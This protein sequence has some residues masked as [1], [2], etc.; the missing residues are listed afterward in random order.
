MDTSSRANLRGGSRGRSLDASRDC[1]PSR[2]GLY[3]SGCDRDGDRDRD[4]DRDRARNRGDSCGRCCGGSC[5]LDCG[6][7]YDC[8]RDERGP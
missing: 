6:M 8:D 5:G 2:C 7:S 3:G 4:R 1:D